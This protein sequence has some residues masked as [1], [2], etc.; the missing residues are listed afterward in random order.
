[1]NVCVTV[2]WFIVVDCYSPAVIRSLTATERCN[3]GKVRL[4]DDCDCSLVG[5]LVG[6]LSATLQTLE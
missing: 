2:A 3:E 4:L 1:M 5:A 6:D